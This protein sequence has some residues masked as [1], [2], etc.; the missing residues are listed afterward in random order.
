MYNIMNNSIT[1]MSAN[2]GKIDIIS[3][4]IANSQTVGYKKLDSG[5]LDLYTD[6]LS[7][8][9]YPHN[10]D[11]LITGTGVKLSSATRNLT[12]GALKETGI[13]TEIAIDGDG[14]FVVQIGKKGDGSPSEG[15]TRDGAFT[16]DSQGKMVTATG[17]YVLT[18]KN[19]A[20]FIPEEAKNAEGTKMRVVSYNI[21]KEGQI[22][23]VLEDGSKVMGSDDPD[24]A[25]TQTLKIATFMNQSGLEANGNNIYLDSANS[26]IPVYNASSNDKDKKGARIGLVTQGALEMSNVDL[27]E[28]FTDMIVTTRA[29]QAA[30]KMITTSDE[31]L[32]EI[33]NLKR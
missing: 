11:N 19:E 10:G 9:S 30:S 2:Q 25:P 7:R 23:Y 15:F 28:E 4:N 8:Q 22:S 29:F 18:T 32:Q 31:L 27:S 12:Q 24:D 6:T 26:G 33:I 16:V 13:N 14:F 5:F 17:Y 20:V 1:A 3:N 21:S